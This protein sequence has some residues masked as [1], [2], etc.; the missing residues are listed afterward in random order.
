MSLHVTTCETTT[1]PTVHNVTSDYQLDCHI[2]ANKSKAYNLS[3]PRTNLTQPA[4]VP[5]PP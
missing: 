3:T 5:Y 1:L 2:F 4:A